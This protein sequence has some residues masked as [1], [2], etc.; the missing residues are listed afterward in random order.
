MKLK[1]DSQWLDKIIS[2]LFV[3]LLA[4][5]LCVTLTQSPRSTSEVEMRKLAVLPTVPS[6]VSELNNLPNA[7]AQYYADHL[8]LIHI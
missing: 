3:A 2:V 7:I 1:T 8:S 4:L 6:N 5:P